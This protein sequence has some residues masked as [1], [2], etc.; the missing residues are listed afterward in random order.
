MH[1]CWGLGQVSVLVLPNYHTLFSRGMRWSK[2]V[3]NIQLP[4]AWGYFLT[5]LV[6]VRSPWLYVCKIAFQLFNCFTLLF[7]KA[8][9]MN[10]QSTIVNIKIN[11]W[12]FLLGEELACHMNW[13]GNWKILLGRTLLFSTLYGVRM[14]SFFNYKIP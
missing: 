6:T 2:K 14:P 13:N 1:F 9:P 12:N 7:S 3:H 8:W 11:K 5:W 4:P 10:S